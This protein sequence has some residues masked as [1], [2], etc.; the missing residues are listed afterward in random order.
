MCGFWDGLKCS[1]FFQNELQGK[2]L[3]G[4]VEHLFS[5]FCP[6]PPSSWHRSCLCTYI[7]CHFLPS[8]PLSIRPLPSPPLSL[9]LPSTTALSWC[10]LLCWFL[11]WAPLPSAPLYFHPLSA[12]SSVSLLPVR[13]PPPQPSPW[14][15]LC[16]HSLQHLLLGV[17]IFFLAKMSFLATRVSSPS[18]VSQVSMTT[19]KLEVEAAKL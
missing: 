6:A 5:T 9:A 10:P 4:G 13:L 7:Y 17:R 14:P 12:L 19:K 3:G 2:Y 8:T 18:S 15:P 16:R 1:A 11:L